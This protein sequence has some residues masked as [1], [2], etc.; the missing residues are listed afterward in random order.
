MITFG[1]KSPTRFRKPSFGNSKSATDPRFVPNGLSSAKRLGIYREQIISFREESRNCRARFLSWNEVL[2]ATKSRRGSSKWM[3]E[4]PAP[5]GLGLKPRW[6][7]PSRTKPVCSNDF[8]VLAKCLKTRSCRQMKIWIGKCERSASFTQKRETRTFSGVEQ[9]TFWA[10]NGS[11][12]GLPRAIFC[13][14]R[15]SV[16][17]RAGQGLFFEVKWLLCARKI[18]SNFGQND[19]KGA[20]TVRSERTFQK[21]T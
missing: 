10:Q 19:Q 12:L 21:C 18:S 17:K 6:I 16:L 1:T 14:R 11:I 8:V 5:P 3:K 2:E 7:W 9:I 15:K 13:A 20:Y 4:L